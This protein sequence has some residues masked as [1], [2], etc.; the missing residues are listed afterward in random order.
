LPDA[1]RGVGLAL[2]ALQDLRADSGDARDLLESKLALALGDE[3][4]EDELLVLVLLERLGV[5]DLTRDAGEGGGGDGAGGLHDLRRQVA[6]VR[7][8]GDEGVPAEALGEQLAEVEVDGVD[9]LRLERLAQ[10]RAG[11]VRALRLEQLDELA[12]IDLRHGG[13]LASRAWGECLGV[14]CGAAGYALVCQ[15][16]M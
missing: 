3:L 8:A 16:P 15:A 12:V 7:A 9:V 1:G 14:R 11:V 5:D 4:G 10:E 6:V 2:L 13:F